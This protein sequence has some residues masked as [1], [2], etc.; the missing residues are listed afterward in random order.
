MLISGTNMFG[1]KIYSYIK[2]SLK[3]FNKLSAAMRGTENFRPSDFGQVVAAGRGEPSPE[4]KQ[5]MAVT[6]GLV[7]VPKP[8]ETG[9]VPAGLSQPKFFD[10][11]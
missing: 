9:A 5:E 8:K 3:N 10:E 4:L 11:E 1:D 2:I 7:D 6:Y